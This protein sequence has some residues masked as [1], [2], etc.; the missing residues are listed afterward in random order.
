MAVHRTC[1][2]ACLSFAAAPA[3]ADVLR[4][5]ADYPTIQAAADAAA[6]GDQIRI[7]RGE[8]CGASIAKRL[9]LVGEGSATI[10]GCAQPN[11]LGLLR[12]GLFFDT[13]PGRAASGSTVHNLRFD[14]GGVSNGNLDPLAFALFA[15][16]V[17]DLTV[18]HN[19]IVGTVQAITNTRGSGW[20]VHHNLI[21][22]L[23][24]FTCDG[25]CG[26]GDAI[27]FQ[28][29]TPAL[30]RAAGNRAQFNVITGR[31]P[32][33]LDEFSMV[34]ILLLGQTGAMLT[35]NRIAIP[36]N[37]AAGGD[38]L[39]IELADACCG[40]PG[41]ILTTVNSVVVN[42]DGRGSEFAVVV[43]VDGDGG[44]GNSAG[45][46][47]RGNFGVNVVNGSSSGVTNRSIR[48]AQIFP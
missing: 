8:W 39:A 30:P 21:E 42:N 17:D 45:T 12:I 28:Q 44:F 47:L 4:V 5:P 15:R 43:D 34:G 22:D 40:I 27:V 7:A 23:T 18:S 29:R 26:G 2:L 16:D 9:D 19:T 33:T 35:N 31:V 13:T 38:G 24:V 32:D 1:L 10:V 46:T 48:F 3:T 20:N 41:S 37:P 25:F 6:P 11:L 36:D 14:G